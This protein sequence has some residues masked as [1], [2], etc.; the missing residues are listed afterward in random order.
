MQLKFLIVPDEDIGYWKAAVVVHGAPP[1]S[2]IVALAVAVPVQAHCKRPGVPFETTSNE[3][4]PTEPVMVV[5]FTLKV[6]PAVSNVLFVKV[7]VVARP[8]KVSVAA[9]SVSVP[10]AAAAD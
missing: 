9:G 8:T 1:A 3:P 7:S 2:E 10:E 5:P 4:S 6:L